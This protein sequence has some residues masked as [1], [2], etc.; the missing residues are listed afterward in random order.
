MFKRPFHPRRSLPGGSRDI[1]RSSPR[2]SGFL[3]PARSIFEFII[4]ESQYRIHERMATP[5]NFDTKTTL[6]GDNRG[7]HGK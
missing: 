6:P 4:P 3:L 1:V 5:W 2:P 7:I